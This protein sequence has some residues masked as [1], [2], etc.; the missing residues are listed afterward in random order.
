MMEVIMGGSGSGKSGYAEKTIVEKTKNGLPRYYIATMKVYGSEGRQRVEKHRKQR[1]YLD[2]VTIE[3]ERDIS[4]AVE[5]MSRGKGA[6]LLECISNLVANEMFG[7]EKTQEEWKAIPAKV[8]QELEALKG[9]SVSLVVVTNNVFEDGNSY[10][11]ETREY[12]DCLA[13]VNAELVKMADV[14]TEVVAGIPI[15]M[16]GAENQC[17][18]GK[19]L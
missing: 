13:K 10:D 4:K 6:V 5:K 1:Q 16:K 18:Y 2:F 7:K 14:V 11:E 12:M 8:L 15:P 9:A 19:V 17:V 3:Q